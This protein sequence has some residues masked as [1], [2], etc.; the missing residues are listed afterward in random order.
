MK[1]TLKSYQD[2]AVSNVVSRISTGVAAF[3]ATKHL[4]H[5]KRTAVS[6][7]AVTGAGKTV[8]AAAVVEQIFEGTPNVPADPTATFLWI[9]DSPDLNTQSRFR[10]EAALGPSRTIKTREVGMDFR[11]EKLQPGTLYFLNIQKLSK[12]STIARRHYREI[13]DQAV[14]MP[15]P[16]AGDYDFW[17]TLDTTINDPDTTL[18]LIVD[19]AHRGMKSGKTQTT[20][21]RGTIIQRVINGSDSIPPVPVVLGISATPGHFLNFMGGNSNFSVEEVRIDASMVQDSGLLKDTIILSIPDEP[22]DYDHALLTQG[23]RRLIEMTQAW[24]SYTAQ[25]RDTPSVQPLMVVQVPDKASDK[26]I[27]SYVETIHNAYPELGIRAFAHVFGEDKAIKAGG[28]L[29]NR[30]PA[31]R[32]QEDDHIRVLFAKE[33]ISTGWDCPRAEV[34]VSFRPAKDE[35]HI[36]QLIGR[37]VRTPL[38][39]RVEGND[40]L[41]SVTCILPKFNRSVAERVATT[42]AQGGTDW[43]GQSG[44]GEALRRVLIDPETVYPAED[45][46]AVRMWE[47]FQTLPTETIPTGSSNPI[48]QLERLAAA[49]SIDGI[50]P[51]IVSETDNKMFQALHG[52]GETFA[53]QVE[54]QIEDIEN[55]QVVEFST[56]YGESKAEEGS[57][58]PITLRA[59]AHAIRVAMRNAERV[60]GKNLAMGYSKWLIGRSMSPNISEPELMELIRSSEVRTAALARIPDVVDQVFSFATKLSNDLTAQHRVQI[61]AL[62]ESKASVYKEIFA[63]AESPQ[64]L[65]LVPP[66]NLNVSTHVAQLD[67]AGNVISKEPIPRWAQHLLISREDEKFP[68]DLNSWES[69]V[70]QVERSR[71]GF[72]GWFRNAGA[73]TNSLNIAYPTADG[74]W[75]RLRP[76]FIFFHEVDGH[77]KASIVDPHSAHLGDA[78]PKLK[79]LARFVEAY[80]GEFW[81]VESVI[82]TD[83]VFKVIDLTDQSVREAVADANN[84]LGLYSIE[85]VGMDYR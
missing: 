13:N 61:R 66:A 2:I 77:V 49:L 3:R 37:M 15:V 12:T 14:L 20:K 35:T 29:I 80:P 21:D 45:D 65:S 30:V 31:E 23:T 25:D 79:G 56:K 85:G 42:V 8:M 28:T 10:I 46:A 19:E 78:L 6:L 7:A 47:I 84:A 33:A 63:Q 81:R 44:N 9:S 11:E 22:G 60:F 48:V 17:R 64:R 43:S 16:D 1:Y 4:P 82:E 75:G 26:L 32:V 54:V 24:S 83:S 27:D 71:A 58:T 38:A 55:I 69:K 72:L 50:K 18:Y 52:A 76:D 41:S 34:M 59:D 40:L 74:G 51:K 5:A 70:V 73:A 67:G 68:A 53:D 57:D 36:T 39:R 62:P